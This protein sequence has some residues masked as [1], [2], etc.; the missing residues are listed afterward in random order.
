LGKATP[1]TDVRLEVLFDALS[2]VAPGFEVVQSHLPDWKFV[3]PQT[4]ADGAPHARR[5]SGA[6]C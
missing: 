1:C 4:V 5:W 2:W 3:A 6:R